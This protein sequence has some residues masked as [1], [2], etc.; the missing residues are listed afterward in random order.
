LD[1]AYSQ[2]GTI[3]A[4]PVYPPSNE[5][6]SLLVHVWAGDAVIPEFETVSGDCS[7]SIAFNS[8]SFSNRFILGTDYVFTLRGLTSASSVACSTDQVHLNLP[9][10]QCFDSILFQRP[11][12]VSLAVNLTA[13][14]SFI[15]SCSVSFLRYN[16]YQFSEP[17]TEKGPCD[18]YRIFESDRRNISLSTGSSVEVSWSYL[19]DDKTSFCS[20][21][22][23]YFLSEIPAPICY[24]DLVLS[25]Q[26]G[27]SIYLRIDEP[28][29]LEGS[30]RLL[31]TGC[32]D[33]DTLVAPVPI[34]MASCRSEISLDYPVIKSKYLPSAV[35]GKSCSFKWGYSYGTDSCTSSTYFVGPNLRAK[36][37]LT[38]VS[39]D[40]GVISLSPVITAEL[41]GSS[42]IVAFLGCDSTL[43]V[44]PIKKVFPSCSNSSVASFSSVDSPVLSVDSTCHFQL[45]QIPSNETF[46]TSANYGCDSGVLTFS[47]SSSPDWLN[48]D[49][50]FQLTL[51]SPGCIELYWG[52]PY[53]TGGA[54]VLCYRIFRKDGFS[55]PW[56][57]VQD[58]GASPVGSR[59]VLSC[60]YRTS[61]PTYFKVVAI[62]KN[63]ESDPPLLVKSFTIEEFLSAPSS[64]ILFD[65]G[66][67]KTASV[68][69]I[70]IQS[71][72]ASDPYPVTDFVTNSKLFVAQIFRDDDTVYLTGRMEP[73]PGFLG[74]YRLLVY[75]IPAGSY[76]LEA[77]SLQ[78]AGILGHYWNNAF[79]HGDQ[80]F[81]RIESE[82]DFDWGNDPIFGISHDLV[83]A[84]WTGWFQPKY[85]E[86]YTIQVETFDHFKLWLNQQLVLD[87]WESSCGGVCSIQTELESSAFTSIRIDYYVSKGFDQSPNSTRM[88][89]KWSSFSQRIET[90]DPLFSSERITGNTSFSVVPDVLVPQM[91]QVIVP[92]TYATAGTLESFFIQAK[93]ILGQNT[94]DLKDSFTCVFTDDSTEVL[95]VASAPAQVNQ[96]N[97][98]Y[99]V[100]FNLTKS[101]TYSITITHIDGSVINTTGISIV[102]ISNDAY[103]PVLSTVSSSFPIT[104]GSPFTVTAQLEDSF[105]NRINGS[106]RSSSFLFSASWLYDEAGNER[107]GPNTNDIKNR[108]DEL[109][110]DYTNFE[111]RWDPVTARFTATLTI[112]V[113]GT[114]SSLI[115]VVDS[116]ARPVMAGQLTVLPNPLISPNMTVVLTKPFPP[117]SGDLVAGTPVTVVVQLRDLYGNPIGSSPQGLEAASPVKIQIRTAEF[118]FYDEGICSA[119]SLVGTYECSVTPRLAASGV[120]SYFSVLVNGVESSY[121]PDQTTGPVSIVPGPWT[122]TVS[123]SVIDA[124]KSLLTGLLPAYWVS[125][126]PVNSVR[127]LLRDAFSNS[128]TDLFGHRPSIELSFKKSDGVVVSSFT[129]YSVESDGAV[130]VPFFLSNPSPLN[131]SDID[132][133][134]YIPHLVIDGVEVYVPYGSRVKFLPGLPS[135]V[136]S[137][138][139]FSSS[140]REAGDPFVSTCSIRDS[141]DNILSTFPPLKTFFMMQTIP[142]FPDIE[143]LSELKSGSIYT[144]STELTI[145][146]NYIVFT[147]LAQP[148]GLVGM[149]YSN[150]DFTNLLFPDIIPMSDGNTYYSRIETDLSD[151]E[152]VD[153]NSFRLYGYLE[154][155]AAITVRFYLKAEGGIKVNLANAIMVDELDENDIDTFF[156][157]SFSSIELQPI[158]I[159]FIRVGAPRISLTWQFPSLNQGAGFMIPPSAL[160]APLRTQISPSTLSVIAGPI[161]SASTVVTQHVNMKIG[162]AE[163]FIIESRDKYGNAIQVQSPCLVVGGSLPACLFEVVQRPED[164]SPAP[165]ISYV[166][167]GEFRVDITFLTDGPKIVSVLLIESASN[168]THL[169]GS[170]FNVTVLP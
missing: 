65:S 164:G 57:L 71:V 56:Y 33:A 83:S 41:P 78:P 52:R 63:G 137:V 32:E 113:S 163:F 61:V 104:A 54:P 31:L 85:T 126:S 101:G 165:S 107:L 20:S 143:T 140:T 91:A 133:L 40:I 119:A 166:G 114:Y 94:T 53:S 42:C 17:I 14:P 45:K 6:C 88:S 67:F 158:S 80:I 9:S 156:D 82:I 157:V 108:T 7:A 93:D 16:Q 90:I 66:P 95:S 129:D 55:N 167:N 146:G 29:P 3:L 142:D 60:G 139:E 30:C 102:V 75:P 18:L 74:K 145:A 37:Y 135:A 89:L 48:D 138:C 38:S 34:Q 168:K 123:P 110:T 128:I 100:P 35:V 151:T 81:N 147:E 160:F 103:A 86:K 22:D 118:S 69:I 125:D 106:I 98:L 79:M 154:P 148:G 97:G 127:I 24:Q 84:Q 153:A 77:W 120:I 87:Y 8:S 4:T 122:V 36:C 12:S 161:S 136:N 13:I 170:P 23:T 10:P 2:Y 27:H 11:D 152:W 116:V 99:I 132:F 162:L 117:I 59:R 112:R 134:G 46:E 141:L 124:S 47:S 109:G 130:K 5:K 25:R 105:G 39:T 159:E 19:A 26:V 50:E 64:I 43:F 169:T 115:S 155:P 62:N 111:T 131:A 1:L 21:D 150:R 76:S 73:E 15:G 96:G 149:F 92:F 121:I 28:Q 51:K 72:L 58:C 68:P 49:S 44:S 144:S 70:R